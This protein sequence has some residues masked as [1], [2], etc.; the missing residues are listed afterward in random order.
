MLWPGMR[1]CQLASVSPQLAS[2]CASLAVFGLSASPCPNN[3]L[4]EQEPLVKMVGRFCFTGNRVQWSLSHVVV[5]H[6]EGAASIR[7]CGKKQPSS[8]TLIPTEVPE[9]WV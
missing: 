9:V 8:P 3:P 4:L 2:Y 1:D 6:G 5:V 7:A